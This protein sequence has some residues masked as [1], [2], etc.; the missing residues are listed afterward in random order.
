MTNSKAIRAIESHIDTLKRSYT[1]QIGPTKGRI[2]QPGVIDEIRAM[3]F[4]ISLIKQESE[5]KR[6]RK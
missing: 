1:D 5:K 4:A 2:T 6:K 3:E